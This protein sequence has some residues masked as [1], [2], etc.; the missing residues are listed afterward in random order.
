MNSKSTLLAAFALGALAITGCGSKSSDNT[1]SS[2]AK[3]QGTVTG[4]RLDNAR[5][6]AIGSNGARAWAYVDAAGR[7]TLTLRTGVSYRVLLLN[8]QASGPDRVSGHVVIGA[9]KSRWVGLNGPATINLGRIATTPFGATVTTASDGEADTSSGSEHDDDAETH[10][11]DGDHEKDDACSDH[12]GKDD[13]ADTSDD[14]DKELDAENDPGDRC[15]D[16]HADDHDR[17]HDGKDD[18]DDKDDKACAASGASSGGGGGAPPPTTGT[19]PAGGA[20]HVSADCAA[21]LTCAAS[22]CVVPIH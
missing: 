2:T 7:F 11:E 3:L 14:D 17:D 10:E 8:A 13:D 4:R 18:D 21:G 1:Q 22:V 20:C 6:L 9:A 16:D 19:V 5:M 15:H 12:D